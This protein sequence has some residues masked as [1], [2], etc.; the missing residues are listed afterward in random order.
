VGGGGVTLPVDIARQEAN[1]VHNEQLCVR[2]Q[3]RR[4]WSVAWVAS[5][6]RGEDTPSEHKSLGGDNKEEDE[7]EK[8]EEEEKRGR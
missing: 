7:E 6:E 1:H 3:R 4:F 8:E 2:R 5:R